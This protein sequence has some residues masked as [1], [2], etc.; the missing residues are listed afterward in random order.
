MDIAQPC[1]CVGTEI[2]PSDKSLRV[3]PVCSKR[4]VVLP[5]QLDLVLNDSGLCSRLVGP[6]Y[7]RQSSLRWF[8]KDCN[9]LHTKRRWCRDCPGDGK[10]QTNIKKHSESQHKLDPDAELALYEWAM[11]QEGSLRTCALNPVANCVPLDLAGKIDRA[12]R[13]PPGRLACDILVF[14]CD[15]ASSMP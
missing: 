13:R 12:R 7:T 11:A 8:C 3:C 10:C 1:T 14:V 4:Y 2:S 5:D 15:P 6:S 9:E